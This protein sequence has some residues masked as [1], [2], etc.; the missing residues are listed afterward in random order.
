[1]TFWR[2]CGTFKRFAGVDA[3]KEQLH[4]DVARR[5]S[6]AFNNFELADKLAA[7]P[8]DRPPDAMPINA[9]MQTE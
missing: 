4:K 1:M 9:G 5:A 6:A 7:R 2:R 3:L 8:S